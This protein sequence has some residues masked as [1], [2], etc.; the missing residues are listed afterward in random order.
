MKST[1][2]SRGERLQIILNNNNQTVTGIYP[3]TCSFMALPQVLWQKQCGG[4]STLQFHNKQMRDQ[5]MIIN[6][7][8]NILLIELK[9]NA[10]TVACQ[11]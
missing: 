9:P 8:L 1:L 10:W 7:C 2:V 11:S 4:P 6:L 5:D 3:P